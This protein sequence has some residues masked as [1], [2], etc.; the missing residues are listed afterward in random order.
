MHVARLTTSHH[1][2]GLEALKRIGLRFGRSEQGVTAVEF[3]L[4]A[5]PFFGLLFVTIQIAL[6]M[7]S[8]QL[9][10]TAVAAAARQLYTGE[11]QKSASNSG[12][13][14]SALQANFKTLVCNN[15]DGFFDCSKVDVDVR[16]FT[17]F[18]TAT[19]ASPNVGGVYDATSYTFQTPARN[20]IVVV[21]ASMQ[22]PNY[23]SFFAPATA[24]NN[25][26][27][28]VMGTAAFRAEPF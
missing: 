13:T 6:V 16:T 8:T 22:Y 17:G 1:H 7:L 12:L 4:V 26:S 15:V 9:L 2:R 3:A 20:D 23:A 24:L 18:S 11:F 14:A 27:Q 10:E 21:R 25:G 5:M 28:L 19:V